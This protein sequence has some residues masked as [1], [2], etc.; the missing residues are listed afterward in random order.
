[1]SIFDDPIIIEM[2]REYNIPCD[3]LIS[4]PKQFQ[5]FVEEYSQRT[6]QK[7]ELPQFARH[8]LLLRKRGEEKGGLP[9][10]RRIYNGRN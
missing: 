7:V 4:D 1:M 5:P 3:T 2:Y 10:L 9:R 6:S 8:L